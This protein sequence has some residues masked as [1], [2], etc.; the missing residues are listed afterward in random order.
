MPDILAQKDFLRLASLLPGFNFEGAVVTAV[1]SLLPGFSRL[2][3]ATP[4]ALSPPLGSF[5]SLRVQAA[6]IA[7]FWFIKWEFSI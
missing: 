7:I 3:D 2:Y 4:L 5:P 1:C 6:V